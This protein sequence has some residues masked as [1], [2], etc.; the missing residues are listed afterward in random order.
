MTKKELEDKN[1]YLQRRNQQLFS[2]LATIKEFIGEQTQRLARMGVHVGW[3]E[4]D[5]TVSL[6]KAIGRLDKFIGDIRHEMYQRGAEKLD[7]QD[8]MERKDLEITKMK[9]DFY[10]KM[11]ERSQNE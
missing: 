10:D 6:N 8:K 2:E 5:P 11:C 9:A 4:N 7:L 3:M 1:N